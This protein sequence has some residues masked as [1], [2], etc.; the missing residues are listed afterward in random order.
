MTKLRKFVGWAALAVAVIAYGADVTDRLGLLPSSTLAGHV[1]N[2]HF[3]AENPELIAL[4][5]SYVRPAS[6]EANRIM[7]FAAQSI[8]QNPDSTVSGYAGLL[9]RSI[10]DEERAAFAHLNDTIVGS[11][12]IGANEIQDRFGEYYRA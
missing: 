12:A 4:F 5:N 2:S 1:S 9:Q 3:R 10:I 6:D 7:T 11:D 8:G